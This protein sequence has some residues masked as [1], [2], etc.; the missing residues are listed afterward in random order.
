MEETEIKEKTSNKKNIVLNILIFSVLLLLI[1]S[2]AE[3]A[4]IKGDIF[5][6]SLKKASDIVVE[7]DSSPKQTMVSKDGSYLFTLSPGNYNLIASKKSGSE[8]IAQA[9][10]KIEIK[11]ESESGEFVIDLI[12]FPVV[13]TNPENSELDFQTTNPLN[14][15][16]ENFN[17]FYIILLGL[18]IIVCMIF[19]AYYANRVLSSNKHSDKPKKNHESKKSKKHSKKERLSNATPKKDNEKA[20]ETKEEEEITKEEQEA[21]HEIRVTDLEKILEILK[22]NDGRATQKEI[23]KEIPLSEAK[24]SLM[25][26]DLEAKGKIRKIKKGRGNIII[27]NHI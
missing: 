20:E 2:S 6:Y 9:E 8:L 12:L 13:E 10:E 11:Q 24:I 5:D 1:A 19:L 21:K 16:A 26:T 22:K 15:D 14:G 23:R 7:I 3:A 4:I 27:L 18:I 25:I 17:T